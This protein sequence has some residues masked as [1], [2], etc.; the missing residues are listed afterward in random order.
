MVE[1]FCSSSLCPPFCS[2][3][4]EASLQPQAGGR[5]PDHR[6]PGVLGSLLALAGVPPVCHHARLW[7]RHHQPTVG[8]VC[9]PL[10]PEVRGQ[11]GPVEAGAGGRL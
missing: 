5:V 6:G 1:M 10:L 4:R 2:D 9:C 8:P 11:V 7:G 3:S